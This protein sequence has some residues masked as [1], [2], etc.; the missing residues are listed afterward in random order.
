MIA[1]IL[2]WVIQTA[3]LQPEEWMEKQIDTQLAHFDHGIQ[4]QQVEK[5]FARIQSTFDGDCVPIVMVKVSQGTCS[6]KGPPNLDK[7]Y[8]QQAENFC[9]A[10]KLLK[11]LPEMALLVCLDRDCERPIYLHAT[12]VPIFA[13]SRSK[14]NAQVV[15]F[16]K[17]ILHPHQSEL[18]TR[19]MNASKVKPWNDRKPVALWRPK[20]LQ[21]E[22]LYN[23]WEWD[24]SV[25]L[26]LL[27]KHYPNDLAFRLSKDF[28]FKKMPWW[29]QKYF[30]SEGLC[31]A[32][33]EPRQQLDY[34]YL[35]ACPQMDLLQDLDWQ[36]FSG[37]LVIKTPAKLYE[38]Y[39]DQL[40]P[41]QHF[42]PIL[43]YGE[44]LTDCIDWLKENDATAKKVAQNAQTFARHYLSDQTQFAYFLAL[45]HAYA[46]RIH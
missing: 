8:F 40:K 34:R 7:M 15:L 29:A 22:Y 37:S 42:I 11:P 3:S 24:P 38:W 17:S 41:Y 1:F 25:R 21:N 5:S 4:I 30:I 45:I 43:T 20:T 35:L 39:Y 27:G 18:Y 33:M 44:D 2:A 10:L 31:T 46:K 28:Y 13:T 32:P 26:L 6:W 12:T 19:V 16:P 23:D 36:L 9:T 14:R